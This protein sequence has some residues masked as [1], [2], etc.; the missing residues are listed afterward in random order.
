MKKRKQFFLGLDISKLFFDA[1]LLTVCSNAKQEIPQ[2]QFANDRAGLQLFEQWLKCNG[3]TYDDNSLVIIENTGIYH[4]LVW[5]FCSRKGLPIHI[6]NAA[7][8]KWSLGITRGKSDK[9]DAQRL[10]NYGYRHHEEL[11]C[12]AALSPVFLQLKD[13]MTNRTRLLQQFTG[14]RSYLKELKRVSDK[15]FSKQLIQYNKA[16]M[17]GLFFFLAFHLF[18][19]GWFSSLVFQYPIANAAKRNTI[20]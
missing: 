8:I 5:K 11:K 18:P 12:T 6:G 19:P 4:R 16:A 2:Q 1:S 17:D 3:V 7:H 13:L 9:I 15:S 14:L 10:S 20:L